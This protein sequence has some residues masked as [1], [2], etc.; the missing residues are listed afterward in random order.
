MM[1]RIML[2]PPFRVPDR[3]DQEM[4]GWLSDKGPPPPRRDTAIDDRGVLQMINGWRD[5]E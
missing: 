2:P 4:N 1:I 3:A 5:G